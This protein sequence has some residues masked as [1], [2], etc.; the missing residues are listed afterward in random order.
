MHREVFR[1][2]IWQGDLRQTVHPADG[3][4]HG[5]RINQNDGGATKRQQ[6]AQRA[7]D[8]RVPAGAR[9]VFR[10]VAPRHVKCAR[11]GSSAMPLKI[12]R[13]CHA[14]C[15][16]KPTIGLIAHNHCQLG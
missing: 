8:D 4:H 2:D 13:R 10:P 14:L 15:R 1:D 12:G 7:H 11:A 16:K 6:P 9:E 3:L 5:Q